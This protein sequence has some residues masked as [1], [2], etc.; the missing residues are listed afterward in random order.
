[1]SKVQMHI[2]VDGHLSQKLRAKFK[3]GEVADR[4]RSYL[5]TL[6]S[7]DSGMSRSEGDTGHIRVN[8]P[9][10][11]SEE[12]PGSPK[13]DVSDRKESRVQRAVTRPATGAVNLGV[14]HMNPVMEKF[15][16]E[17]GREKK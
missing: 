1:M 2:W 14:P 10:G 16:K 4:V 11:V 7:S 3:H 12:V 9:P 8:A 5:V 17:N 6:L 13:P 15:L